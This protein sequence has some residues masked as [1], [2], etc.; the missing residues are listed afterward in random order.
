MKAL[1][2]WPLCWEINGDRWIP[3]TNDQSRGKC[4]HLMTSSWVASGPVLVC[5]IGYHNMDT[6]SALLTLCENHKPICDA[7]LR[8]FLFHHSTNILTFIVETFYGE[9]IRESEGIEGDDLIDLYGCRGVWV[10]I[11]HGKSPRGIKRVGHGTR[12]VLDVDAET[13]SRLDLDTIGRQ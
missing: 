11:S 7:E 6:F 8:Y 10:G 13:V 9:I 2:H 5:I 1:C 12:G 4:F 3:H